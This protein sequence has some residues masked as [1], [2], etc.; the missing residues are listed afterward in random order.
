M[1]RENK[2]AQLMTAMQTGKRY[3]MQTLED[4]LNEL[5]INGIISYEDATAKANAPEL[6]Q[7]AAGVPRPART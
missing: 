2:M 7:P 6:I 5:V 1:I 3:G 4:H